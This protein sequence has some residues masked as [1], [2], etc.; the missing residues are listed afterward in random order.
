MR[1]DQAQKKKIFL[2]E[3]HKLM[4]HLSEFTEKLRKHFNKIPQK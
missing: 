1:V 3:K 4:F 2:C